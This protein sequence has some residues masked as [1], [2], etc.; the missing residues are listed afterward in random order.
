MQGDLV[1][2]SLERRRLQR[3]LQVFWEDVEETG[4]RSQIGRYSHNNS[5][6]KLGLELSTLWEVFEMRC[7]KE[8]WSRFCQL[9]TCVNL[10]NDSVPSPCLWLREYNL[11]CMTSYLDGDRICLS[12]S[13]SFGHPQS[14]GSL[15]WGLLCSQFSKQIEWV[16]PWIANTA[17]TKAGMVVSIFAYFWIF[18]A[19]AVSC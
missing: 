15:Q 9:A 2:F 19:R 6:V 4:I 14:T 13:L 5:S 3:N 1:L 17:Y 12:L 11:H 7:F 16:F 8:N 10:R 18:S